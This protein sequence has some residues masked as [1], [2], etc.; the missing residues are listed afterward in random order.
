M[1]IGVIGAG[2]IGSVLARG[3]DQLGHDVVINDVDADR[4]D[5][6]PFEARPKR[7][8][9]LN[10]DVA[11]FAV[12]TPTTQTGGDASAVREALDP[13][14]EGNAT[15]LL[16]S[17]M[18]P[19]STARL[20]DATGLDLVYSPEFLRDRSGVEDFFHLD[21]IVLAGPA[22]ERGVIRALLDDR[23][24]DCD[25][26]IETDDYL[27]AE[28]AKE[29][30]NAFFAT[31]VSFANQMRLICEGAGADV[32]AVMDVVTADARNTESHLDPLLGPYGGK[33]LPK[34]TEALTLFAEGEGVDVPQLRG[35]I[36]TNNIAKETFENVD[37]TGTYPDISVQSD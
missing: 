12:P 8:I 35:T 9:A 14:R 11:V 17:T 1:R 13:F 28:I 30:H 18:P 31:K 10:A 27:T 5:A 23:R 4:E 19:G 16:R 33:C 24:I 25:T 36:A 29:A 34:D 37:I 32:E 15:C 3:F 26:V 22:H 6:L 2:S 20:A 7:W 21:R